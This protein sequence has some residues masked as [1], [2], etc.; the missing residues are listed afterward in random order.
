MSSRKKWEILNV[1]EESVIMQHILKVI[2]MLFSLFKEAF[3]I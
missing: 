2:W 1:E 3:Q